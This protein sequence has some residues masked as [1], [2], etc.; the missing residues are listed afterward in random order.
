MTTDPTDRRALLEAGVLAEGGVDGIYHR[1]FEFEHV[2]RGVERYVSSAGRAPLARRLFM[3]P[4][5]ARTT[6][7]KSGY[8]TSFPNLVGVIAGLPDHAAP[9]ALADPASWTALVE[10]TD[11]APCSAACHGL[12][13][14][15][16]DEVV[17]SEGARYEVQSWCFRHEPSE[18]P[19]RM[20]AFRQHEFVVIG[21]PEQAIAHRDLWL[22]RGRGLLSALGLDVEPVVA[23][24][25]FFG[26]AASLLAESQRA[27]ELK[28]ELVAQVATDEPRA[29][30]SANYHEDH[31]GIAFGLRGE[32]GSV[33]H[34]ACIGFGLERIT[35]ALFRRHGYRR[36]DWPSDV[37][38][39]LFGPREDVPQTP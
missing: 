9:V 31:F 13:P 8:I 16:A 15:V 26:R 33:A 3:S 14:L 38:A 5:L 2:V 18:D 39:L 29:I 34:T 12:Y 4:L 6:L 35:L 30:S 25:P 32:D 10:P 21:T 22:E 28:F 7:E 19:A 1:S 27:K 17:A 37:T 24:D 36:E 11:V 20:Q 23:N